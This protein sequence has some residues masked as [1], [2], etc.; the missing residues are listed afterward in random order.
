[1]LCEVFIA[2]LRELKDKKWHGTEY[3]QQVPLQWDQGKPGIQYTNIN[4]SPVR[5]LCDIGH[6]VKKTDKMFENEGDSFFLSQVYTIGGYQPQHLDSN[7]KYEFKIIVSAE[8]AKA[9]SQKF[10]LYWTGKWKDDSVEMFREI[11]I[12]RV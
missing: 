8:N 9:I 5:T 6:I 7:K 3:F 12:K 4:P 2:E 10:E 1:R 11:V